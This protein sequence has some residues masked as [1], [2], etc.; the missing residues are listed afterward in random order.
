MKTI[1]PGPAV[2]LIEPLFAASHLTTPE[3]DLV[4]DTL[5]RVVTTLTTSPILGIRRSLALPP[6]VRVESGGYG[7]IVSLALSDPLSYG[8]SRLL[9]A[10]LYK[11]E[12]FARVSILK[13][14]MTVVVRLARAAN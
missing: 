12:R 4:V 9:A 6:G 1:N 10:K 8:E 13:D 14:R 7:D 3:V 5:N 11:D 2:T